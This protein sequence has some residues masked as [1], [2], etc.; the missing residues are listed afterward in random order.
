MSDD[1]LRR[2]EREWGATNDQEVL[3]QLILAKKRAGIV[4]DQALLEAQTSPGFTFTS[5]H[6][7]NVHVVDAS[8]EWRELGTSRT[9]RGQRQIEIPPHK[10]WGFGLAG[11]DFAPMPFETFAEA[12]EEHRPTAVHV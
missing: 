10:A 4:V 7:L 5:R 8:F 2:L 1:E 11:T 3:A 6:D 9:W 12:V